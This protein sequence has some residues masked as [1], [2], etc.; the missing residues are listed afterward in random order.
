MSALFIHVGNLDFDLTEVAVPW[1]L[2]TDAGHSVVFATEKGATPT[3]DEKLIPGPFFGML[4]SKPQPIIFYDQ[5]KVDPAF[6][7]PLA[8]SAVVPSEFDALLLPGGHAPGMRQYIGSEE[9]QG[10]VAQ[11]W[12]LQRPVAAVCHGVLVLARARDAT[13][14]SLLSGVRTTCL[15]YY[16]ERTVIRLTSWWLGDYYA[17]YPHTVQEE[18]EA[19]GAVFVRGTTTLFTHGT[20]T[21]DAGT[22]VVQDGRY[23]SAR[24][25]GDAYAFARALIALLN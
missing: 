2:L 4:G 5:L 23:I 13:G 9:L 25:P 3:G 8:W 18:V 16:M 1:R 6:C 19:A 10:I 15:P 22:H 14:K 17:T 7:S 24:W 11:F 12:A 21:S 20:S